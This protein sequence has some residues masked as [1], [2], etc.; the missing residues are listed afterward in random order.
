MVANGTG[1]LLSSS[2]LP[3]IAGCAIAAALQNMQAA[4]MQQPILFIKGKASG[5]PEVIDKSAF[6]MVQIYLN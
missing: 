6:E 4:I 1:A 3:S 5:L 2:T